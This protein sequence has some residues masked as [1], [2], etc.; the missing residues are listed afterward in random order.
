MD[1]LLEDKLRDLLDRDAILRVMHRFA[2]GVD[3]MDNAL[4]LSCY[5][6]EAIEDHSQ[7]V[8]TPADFVRYADAMTDSFVSCQH[9]LTTHNCELAGDNAYAETGYIFT[10]TLA[11]PP[12]FMSTGR[13]VDHF[14]RRGSEWRI[15]NRVTIVEANYGLLPS[16]LAPDPKSAY[17]PGERFPGTRDK[18]D[19]SY[20]RPPVP[21]RP[22]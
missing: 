14:Q 9:A 15:A 6:P 7:F 8:G 4:T 13:Y 12:H 10:G 11:A 20:Q 17:A 16:E 22:K 3:R 5:W 21:R 1:V 18:S 19:A 2:R